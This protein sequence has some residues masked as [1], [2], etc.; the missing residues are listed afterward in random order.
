MKEKLAILKAAV[1]QANEALAKGEITQDQYDALQR[2]IVETEQKV[3]A[4][5]KQASDSSV[6]LQKIAATG[7]K[8][9]STGDTI[10]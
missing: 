6:A 1:G 2:E 4:L 8:L 3:K 5:E 9:T 7:E 10:A